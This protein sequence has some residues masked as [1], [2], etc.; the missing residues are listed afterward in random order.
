[1]VKQGEVASAEWREADRRRALLIYVIGALA[2]AGL[3]AVLYFF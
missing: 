1:M 3:T 2:A